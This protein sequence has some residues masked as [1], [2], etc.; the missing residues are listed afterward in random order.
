MGSAL[1]DTTLGLHQAR[2]IAINAACPQGDAHDVSGML[3]QLGIVQ[4]DSI[5]VLARAHQLAL[6]SR[7]PHLTATEVDTSLWKGSA[8]VAFD[9]PAHALALVPLQDWPLWAFRRRVTRTRP[10]YPDQ[11]TSQAMIGRIEKHGPLTMRELR[12]GEEPGSG[13]DWGPTKVSVEFLAWSGELVCARRTRWQ[14]VFDLPQRSIPSRYLTDSLTDEECLLQLLERA[15]RVLGVAAVDDLADYI[16]IKARRVCELLPDTL[17]IPVAVQGWAEQA[18]AHPEALAQADLP[19]QAMFVGPFDN[20]IWYRPRVARLFHFTQLLE[21]YKRPSQRTHGYYVCPLLVGSRLV[22]RADFAR[23]AHALTILRISV[24][25]LSLE[26]LD[27]F[28]QACHRLSEIVESPE[29]AIADDASD[30]R[31]VRALRAALHSHDSST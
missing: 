11:R 22:G 15:G 13:W 29:I 19:D 20:L 12:G 14:R 31:T 8:P 18:W 7:V 27:G 6:A 3:S 23:H 10:E 16:R 4:L 17:L 24:D 28:T 5:N 30:P 1:S 2:A 25:S 21:A 9:Y 26:I